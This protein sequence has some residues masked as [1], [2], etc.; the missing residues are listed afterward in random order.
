MKC[1]LRNLSYARLDVR[2][3]AGTVYMLLRWWFK[4]F[5]LPEFG[6]VKFVNEARLQTQEMKTTHATDD[7]NDDTDFVDE[8]TTDIDM[9]HRKIMRHHTT[10]AIDRKKG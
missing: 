10:R 6:N 2:S 3:H 4:E 9:E 1:P 5:D 7:E 8:G